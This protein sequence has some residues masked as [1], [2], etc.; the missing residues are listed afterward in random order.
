MTN[1][2]FCYWLQGYFEISKM[3]TLTKEKIAI[4]NG[5]LNKINEPFGELTQW[6]TNVTAF[7]SEQQYKQVFLDLFLIEIQREL[8]ALFLH[9][10]DNNH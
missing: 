3:T 9:V 5:S 1:Q 8:N 6:L 4:I 10:I 2:E 7:F